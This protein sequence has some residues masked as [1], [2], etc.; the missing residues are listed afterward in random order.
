MWWQVDR[1]TGVLGANLW[2]LTRR[3]DRLIVAVGRHHT[4]VLVFAR[5]AE[6][7]E[8][9]QARFV[10]R[11][12]PYDFKGSEVFVHRR[13]SKET[14]VHVVEGCGTF[15]KRTSRE[16]LPPGSRQ[17]VLAAAKAS[18][19]TGWPTSLEPLGDVARDE[20]PG[21][22]EGAPT[23]FGAALASDPARAGARVMPVGSADVLAI[24]EAVGQG[25]RADG[26]TSLHHVGIAPNAEPYLD[27]AVAN[28]VSDGSPTSRHLVCAEGQD[29][30]FQRHLELALS[31]LP[32]APERGSQDLPPG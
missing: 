27:H 19:G 31:E 24:P 11:L 3:L 13:C 18:L 8:S 7:A 10:Q 2:A 22:F 5:S 1:Y 14:H 16:Q 29:A 23:L 12:M 32:D 15:L 4:R 6:G 25:G 30:I 17:L 26:E 21:L 9:Q 28:L 20:A